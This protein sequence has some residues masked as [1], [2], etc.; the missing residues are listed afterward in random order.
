MAAFKG[1]RQL[2]WSV[3]LRAKL[4]VAQEI[5][6][7]ILAEKQ[8]D[9]RTLLIGTLS[10]KDWRIVRRCRGE[11]ALLDA[12]EGGPAALAALVEQMYSWAVKPKPKTKD[13]KSFSFAEPALI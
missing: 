12:A 4:E 13:L 3:K 10:V 1:S 9:E 2:H 8:E 7:E 6:D 5:S 11:S